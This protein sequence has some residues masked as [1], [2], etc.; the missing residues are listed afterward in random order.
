MLIAGGVNGHW[1]ADEWMPSI[2]ESAMFVKCLPAIESVCSLVL[3]FC[4][5]VNG[6]LTLSRE[7]L[8]FHWILWHCLQR[9]LL[10]V[11]VINLHS[12]FEKPWKQSIFC[13]RAMG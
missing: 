7:F 4:S 1:K 5:V 3:L 8:G 2:V 6:W 11:R 13:M 9:R 12:G 10:L